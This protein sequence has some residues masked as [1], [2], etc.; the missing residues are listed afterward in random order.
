MDWQS[1]QPLFHWLSDHPFWSGFFVFLIAL[2]ESLVIVGLIVP[3]TVLMFGVGTLVGTGVLDIKL[4]LFLAFAGAVLGDGISFWIGAKYRDQ[5]S[6]FWPF[7]NNPQILLKGKE[8][9]TRHGGK[10][11]F[12]GRFVG[13]VRP[14]IPAVAGMMHMPANQ[15]LF[16]NVLSAAGWAPFYLIPGII[17]GTSIG[18]ASAIGSRL[19]IILLSLFIGIGLIVFLIRK[20]MAYAT[21][22]LERWFSVVMQWSELQIY[23]EQ[24]SGKQRSENI[25]SLNR[26]LIASIISAFIDPK[27][28]VVKSLSVVIVLLICLISFLSVFIF[29]FLSQSISEVNLV[30]S[31]VF[32]LLR[33]TPGDEFMWMIQVAMS[34]L[35]LLLFLINLFVNFLYSGTKKAFFYFL[36]LLIVTL[37]SS[38]GLIFLVEYI[39]EKAINASAWIQ[40]SI[41]VSATLF[42]VVVASESILQPRRWIL[43]SFASLL[44]LIF[45]FSNLYFS[46]LPVSYLF[47]ATNLSVIWVILFSLAY[48]RHVHEVKSLSFVSASSI[49][50]L[51]LTAST[52]IHSGLYRDVISEMKTE[53]RTFSRADWQNKVWLALSEKRSDVFGVKKYFLNLQWHGEINEIKQILESSG[54]ILS[55]DNSL[56]TVLYWLAPEPE[57]NKI[58]RLP[59]TH[60][61]KTESLLL[62]KP[63]D[64]GAS[65]DADGVAIDADERQLT[66]QLWPSN[67]LLE[68]NIPVWVGLLS[69]QRL[70][71]NERWLPFFRVENA[72]VSE[73]LNTM[74]LDDSWK[75]TIKERNMPELADGKQ[76]ILLLE[77]VNDK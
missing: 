67:V 2:T 72:S 46:V 66:L 4:V 48:R 5:I 27:K 61:G 30:V 58:T 53:R 77:K 63:Y 10:S 73:L 44:I 74:E 56:K 38:Y 45:C 15:F 60:N 20:T 54:W 62:I 11:I 12:F 14:V 26:Y 33:T 19:V 37:I 25:R 40:V 3:G 31:N 22:K 70:V 52:M 41:L 32:G 21:P 42:Y 9:F 24:I 36:L 47:L 18:L 75:T 13:P 64:F 65:G 55:G 51:I 43:Y 35:V 16:I 23:E 34:W 1:I 68:N 39:T 50:I 17:F 28:N 8:F 7:K 69:V 59:Q 49:L 76:K 57:L 29:G 6:G 71:S